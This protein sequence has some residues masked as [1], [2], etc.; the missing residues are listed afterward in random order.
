MLMSIS[1][2]CDICGEPGVGNVYPSPVYPNQQPGLTLAANQAVA[3]N[4][5]YDLCAGHANVYTL[6]IQKFFEKGA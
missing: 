6:M 2:S 1:Y 3:Q 5:S 4:R